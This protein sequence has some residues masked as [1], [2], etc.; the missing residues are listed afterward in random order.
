MSE[1]LLLRHGTAE[2]HG[3]PGHDAHRRLVARGEDEARTAGRALVALDR[4]PDVVL[5]SP[6]VRAWQTAELAVAAWGGSVVE[7]AAVIGLDV[8][9]AL[10]LAAL[11]ARVLVVGHEPDLSQV[12]HGLTGGR[13]KMRKGGLAV[14]QVGGGGRLDALLGPRELERIG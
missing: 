5:A 8:D 12:V 10:G 1:L 9:E 11:G 14:L 2:P 6:K 3:A 4:I 13:A 7:H